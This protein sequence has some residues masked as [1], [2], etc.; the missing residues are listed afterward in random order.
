MGSELQKARLVVLDP[1]GNETGRE[2]VCVYNPETLSYKRKPE[3]SPNNVPGKELAELQRKG[4]GSASLTV[5]LM[6]DTTRTLQKSTDGVDVTAGA[7]VRTYSEFFFRVIEEVEQG[8]PSYCRF[9]WGKKIY[10]IKGMLMGFD[11][12]YKLFAPDGTPLRSEI[13]ITL[14]EQATINEQDKLWQN[15][16]TRSEARKIRVVHEGERLDNIAYEEYRDAACWRLIA[17]A[18]GIEDPFRVR[19]GRVLRVPPRP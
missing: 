16:T 1:S 17:E 12:T 19:P 8:K 2:L 15:P 14:E 7:D 13:T 9:E 5:T 6:F 10:V 18:N 3:I 11:V 4:G